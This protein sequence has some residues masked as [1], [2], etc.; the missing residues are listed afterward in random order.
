MRHLRD[1]FGVVFKIQ[2]VVKDRSD[3]AK[4]GCDTRILLSCTGVGYVNVSKSIT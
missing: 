4:T 2:S 1:F 3:E